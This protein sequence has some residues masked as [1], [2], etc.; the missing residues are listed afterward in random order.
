MLLLK[1]LTGAYLLEILAIIECS[2]SISMGYEYGLILDYNS[3][4]H[5]YATNS[6]ADVAN[7]DVYLNFVET[8]INENDND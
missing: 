2:T 1:H 5:K 8:H 4:I 3:V 6:D 7:V